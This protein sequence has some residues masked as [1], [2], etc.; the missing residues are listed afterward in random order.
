MKKFESPSIQI[1]GMQSQQSILT[2]SVDPINQS[3]SEN[4]ARGIGSG[5]GSGNGSSISSQSDLNLDVMDF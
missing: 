3:T 4:L 2:M 5:N 1:V